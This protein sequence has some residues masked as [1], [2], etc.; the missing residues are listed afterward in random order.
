M[1]ITR[2]TRRLAI[3]SAAGAALA[4]AG[5]GGGGGSGGDSG[6]RSDDAKEL[7]FARCMREAGIDFPDP[8]PAANGTERRAIRLP[9]GISPERLQTIDSTCRRKSGVVRQEPSAEEQ[10][11]FRDDALKFARCMRAHGV[12]VPDPQA[13]GGGIVI[14]RKAGSGASGPNPDSPAFKRAQAA[15]P[16]GGKVG[17][18]MKGGGKF[19]GKVAGN[20]VGKGS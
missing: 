18:A 15:C 19:D 20:S 8:K 11:K 6:S 5:C 1:T 16:S 12:D 9:R 7:A 10:A 17:D 2:W 4:A 3:A 13:R 14:Q